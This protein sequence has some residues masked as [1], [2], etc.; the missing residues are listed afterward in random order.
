VYME[1]LEQCDNR[2]KVRWL[3]DNTVRDICQLQRFRA[4]IQISPTHLP[5]SDFRGRYLKHYSS[6]CPRRF[7]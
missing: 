7:D 1:L 3:Y 2:D 6:V 4:L 5:H